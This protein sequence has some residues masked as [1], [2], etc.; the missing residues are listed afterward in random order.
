MK[1]TDKKAVVCLLD[2]PTPIAYYNVYKPGDIWIKIKGCEECDIEDRKKCCGNCPHVT[3]KGDCAWQLEEG[4][5]SKPWSCIAWP[6]PKQANSRCV[7][8]FKCVK[9][10]FKGKIRKVRN[11]QK[12]AL[13]ALTS[14]QI[15]RSGVLARER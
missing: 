12:S 5:S 15:D 3:A 8:E 11:L 10:K 2:D 13:I 14:R 1:I 4:R 7:L 6:T 9:G